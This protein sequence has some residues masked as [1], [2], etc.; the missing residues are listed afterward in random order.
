MQHVSELHFYKY[1]IY[2]LNAWLQNCLETTIGCIVPKCSQNGPK[3]LQYI[4]SG[5]TATHHLECS[6]CRNES[7]AQRL[8]HAIFQRNRAMEVRSTTLFP[9]HSVHGRVSGGHF[10]RTLEN[11][12]SASVLGVVWQKQ[13]HLSTIDIEVHLHLRLERGKGGG[14]GRPGILAR[15]IMGATCHA[16][17]VSV[18]YVQTLQFVVSKRFAAV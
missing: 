13:A 6:N 4:E 7:A 10:K 11:V 9:G 18:F 1:C 14:G 17:G 2:F 5:P 16:P 15:Y 8:R 12:M 3:V